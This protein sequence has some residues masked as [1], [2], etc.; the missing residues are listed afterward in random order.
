MGNKLNQNQSKNR[1]YSPTATLNNND[2]PK[3]FWQNL[4]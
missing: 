4:C 3:E 1:T 2:F